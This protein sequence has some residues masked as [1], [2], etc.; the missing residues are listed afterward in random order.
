M[1][2]GALT[3]LVGREEE[4]ELLL[5]R[6]SRR[7]PAKDKWSC[8]PVSR[9]SGK[10]RL[11]AALMDRLAGDRGEPCDVVAATGTD[12]CDGYT[13]FDA[14]QTYELGRFI[15]GVALLDR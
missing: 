4:L 13:G 1:H 9:A 2:A 15:G 3:E 8:C 12:V 7:R 11:T 14:K 5:R 10:S 6:W